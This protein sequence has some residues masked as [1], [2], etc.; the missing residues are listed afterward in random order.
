MET[1][2][3]SIKYDS[4]DENSG[5]AGIDLDGPAGSSVSIGITN[6]A[7][8]DLLRRVMSVSEDLPLLPG[9]CAA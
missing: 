2:R 5:L 1:Y 9:V 4:P 3:F 7:F 8:G 6:A